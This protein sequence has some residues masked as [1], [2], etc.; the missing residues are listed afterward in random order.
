[1]IAAK[2]FD[3]V[4]GMDIHI[5]LIPTPGGP[6]PTPLPHIYAGMVFDPFD[7]VPVIGQTISV[8]GKLLLAAQPMTECKFFGQV[9]MAGP[10]AK[11]PEMVGEIMLGSMTVGTQSMALADMPSALLSMP[12]AI[13]SIP[14]EFGKSPLG[15][16][17]G[18][19]MGSSDNE[20]APEPPPPDNAEPEAPANPDAPPPPEPPPPP[21]P[22]SVYPLSRLGDMIL[23]CADVGAPAPTSGDKKGGIK[24]FTF[25]GG[26]VMAIPMGAPVLI[27]G[28]PAPAP[29]SAFA[30][31]FLMKFGMAALSK[32]LGGALRKFNDLLQTKF[33]DNPVSN[34]LCDWGFEP[35]DIASGKVMTSRED[36][37]LPGPIPLVW[38]VFIIPTQD[39]LMV[40]WAHVGVILTTC[41]SNP[42]L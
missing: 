23:G 3:P 11:P 32:A 24:G 12:A 36:F 26:V 2:H 21:P 22:T 28:G 31:K 9:P 19:V 30:M 17:V 33:G 15:A 5:N 8:N 18:D 34:K 39:T 29:L 7:F 20:P 35:V 13:A 37:A 4:M 27:G 38:N 40:L 41:T 14:G 6:V 25:P 42:T 1:M 16:W 10:F